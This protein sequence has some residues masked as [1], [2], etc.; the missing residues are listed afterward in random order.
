M[1]KNPYSHTRFCTAVLGSLSIALSTAC[2]Q[3]PRSAPAFDGDT[4]KALPTS[5][6]I[7]NGGNIYNQRYSPLTTINRDNVSELKGVWRA[8]LDGSGVGEKYS[9]EATP[10]VYDGVIY[11]VTGA[12]DV[13]AISVETGERLWK[14]EASLDQTINSVCCG[15]TS[16]GVAIGDGKVFVGQLDGQL[17]ALGA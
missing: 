8:R 12:D 2:A 17:I 5:G 13:F 11:I 1:D 3:E 9:G 16:R 10:I 15:W 7:T 6:W 14:Y 4:L